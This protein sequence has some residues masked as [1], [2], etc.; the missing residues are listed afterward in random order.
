MSVIVRNARLGDGA[1]LHR[2]IC[3]LA[4][5][6]GHLDNVVSTAEQLEA[7]LCAAS[8]H[9]GCLVAEADGEVVGLAY[10]YEVFTTFTARNKIYLEDIVVSSGGRGTGA[11]F[12]LIKRLAQLC[13]E[14]GCPRFEW[15]AMSDNEA[16]QKFYKRTGGKV[17]KGAETWQM[18]GDEIKALAEAEA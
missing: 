13:V 1:A 14:R 15:L 12:A 5:H 11:G 17:L 8:D 3:D 10:W 4:E 9:R 7:V 6:H 18:W 2:L 16:G